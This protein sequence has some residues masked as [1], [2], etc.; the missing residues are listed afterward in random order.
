[1]RLGLVMA[2]ALAL[3]GPALGQTGNAAK[4]G[5]GGALKSLG[6]LQEEFSKQWDG[7]AGRM[8][9]GA[10]GLAGVAAALSAAN[11]AVSFQLRLRGDGSV[12]ASG[13][14]GTTAAPSTST[15]GSTSSSTST[16]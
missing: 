4:T 10:I 6:A 15:S 1:M 7:R 8:T 5:T 13:G 12:D 14:S 2:L 9:K 3:S 16:N 11:K